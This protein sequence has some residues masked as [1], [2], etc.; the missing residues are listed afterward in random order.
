MIHFIMSVCFVLIR[1]ECRCRVVSHFSLTSGGSGL[2]SRNGDLLSW[3]GF[4]VVFVGF[5][6]KM[7]KY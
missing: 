2:K 7:L 6:R 4:L 3:Q 5:Y 1:I